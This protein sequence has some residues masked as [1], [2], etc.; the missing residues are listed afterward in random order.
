MNNFTNSDP[1][2][3]NDCVDCPAPPILPLATSDE[4]EP[5]TYLG[6]E[7]LF[8]T[9]PL[10]DA[11][12]D[13][14]AEAHQPRGIPYADLNAIMSRDIGQ[15]PS[16]ITAQKDMRFMRDV[17]DQMKAKMGSEEDFL[18]FLLVF[19]A[20][21]GGTD[22]Q[23]NEFTVT[24]PGIGTQETGDAVFNIQFLPLRRTLT[25][26]IS[27]GF[28]KG[29]SVVSAPDGTGAQFPET[30]HVNVSGNAIFTDDFTIYV[31]RK[32]RVFDIS[33]RADLER[34][35]PGTESYRVLPGE[36]SASDIADQI[37]DAIGTYMASNQRTDFWV[38]KGLLVAEAALTVACI[39]TGVGALAVAGRAASVAIKAGIF[40]EANNL[41]G[42][43]LEFIGVPLYDGAGKAY[44]PL[45]ALTR[46]A[47]EATGAHEAAAR[48]EM[49]IHAMNLCMAFGMSARTKA[50]SALAT[51]GG[52]YLV[53]DSLQMDQGIVRA[54]E[55]EENRTGQG[56]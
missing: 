45:I 36:A 8:E 30:R 21:R 6:I 38:S 11:S 39:A 28:W 4:G 17:V 47:G 49:S 41:G 37:Y 25:R 42:A 44:N 9:G 15:T 32:V 31:E 50:I 53:M 2:P 43:V 20:G 18:R 22:D 52:S 34:I 35:S 27:F 13:G 7:S 29:S 14:T 16:A 3:S 5:S 19:Q 54:Y 40:L 24:I 33:N 48:L 12:V 1:M 56:G 51:S 10:N 55:E 23:G 26:P 46:H